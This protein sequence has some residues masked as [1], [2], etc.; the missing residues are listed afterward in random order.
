MVSNRKGPLRCVAP[1]LHAQ[2]SFA[3]HRPGTG[4]EGRYGGCSVLGHGLAHSLV[5]VDRLVSSHMGAVGDGR[6]VSGPGVASPQD[7]S[8]RAPSQGTGRLGDLP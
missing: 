7:G 2:E 3:L 5:S 4:D 8:S 6:L 1:L